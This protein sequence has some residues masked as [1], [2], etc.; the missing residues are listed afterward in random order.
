MT[1]TQKGW[2]TVGIVFLLLVVAFFVTSFVLAGQHGQSVVTEWQSWGEAIKN[3][4]VPVE[5][6]VEEAV[7]TVTSK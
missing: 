5:E 3:A 6:V 4:F 2:L 1:K 7:D